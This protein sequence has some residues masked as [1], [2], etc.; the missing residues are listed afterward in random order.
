[1]VFRYFLG[2]LIREAAQGKLQQTAAEA[3]AAAERHLELKC[4]VLVAMALPI[5]AGGFLDC[6]AEPS[7]MKSAKFTEH[8]GHLKKVGGEESVVVGIVETGVGQ[9]SAGLVTSQLIG[10]RQ[11]QWVVS[12]GFAGGL[13]EDLPRNQFLMADRVRCA[14]SGEELS[15]GLSMG[16]EPTDASPAVHVG[17]LLTVDHLVRVSNQ[18]RELG[19]RHD[20][21]ACDME[22]FAVTKA[23]QQSDTRFLSVRI[24]SDAVDDELPKEISRLLDQKT[25]AAQLGA[26][27]AALWKR[28]SSAK[29]MWKLKE[30]AIACSDRLAKFL[31]G[32]ILQLPLKSDDTSAH[33]RDSGTANES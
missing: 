20:A 3:K 9:T 25:T 12:A 19:G 22:S 2:N 7:T 16:N 6:L 21:L 5:E 32:V 29:D 23:C 10:L 14:K 24:I 30:D 18:K 4:D 27:A 11:P 17:R 13:H 31:T 26:A 8:I 33:S 1:M 28:P 15:V